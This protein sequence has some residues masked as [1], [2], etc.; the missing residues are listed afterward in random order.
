MRAALIVALVALAAPPAAA[1]AQP[2]V[3]ALTP[4]EKLVEA[5]SQFK[6]KQWQRAAFVLE[7]LLYPTSELALK[8]DVIEVHMLLGAS[9]FELDRRAEAVREFEKA[10][11]LSIDQGMSEWLYSEGAIKLFEDTKA[12]I[13][14]RLAAE[15]KQK[16]IAEREKRLREYI[17]TIG[18]YETRSFSQNFF[19]LG[20]PQSQNG[21]RTKAWIV[22]SAQAATFAASAGAFLYLAGKYGLNAKVP[23]E[24]GPRVRQI[25]QFEIG[26]GVAF[27]LIYAYSVVD[28]IV[29][30]KPTTRI[31]GDDTIRDLLDL[32]KKPA[33]P[34]PKKTSLRD[35]LRFAPMLT[36]SGVGLG[37]AWETD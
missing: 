33:P 36:P 9:H 5:R 32:D 12:R 34:K 19:P 2:I 4:A 10:L 17:D 25:Q 13:R 1:D 20:F 35:R 23:L 11:E 6:Q 28:G 26:A 3:K 30:F 29:Y 31:K 14:E 37:V 15:A 16:E 7:D 8:T 27:I 24:D 22:G 18:V 21:H